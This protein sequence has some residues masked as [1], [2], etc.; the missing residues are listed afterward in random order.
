MTGSI[1]STA[2]F[3][4]TYVMSKIYK[5]YEKNAVY[6]FHISKLRFTITRI[7]FVPQSEIEN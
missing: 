5:L 7:T 3:G 1:K 4:S 6:S 2:T